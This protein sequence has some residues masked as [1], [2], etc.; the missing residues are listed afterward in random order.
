MG[1]YKIGGAPQALHLRVLLLGEIPQKG[2]CLCCSI[3]R[4]TV[5][6]K[7]KQKVLGLRV[8]PSKTF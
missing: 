3:I 8:G 4:R 6:K 2:S 5:I 1:T 7:Y